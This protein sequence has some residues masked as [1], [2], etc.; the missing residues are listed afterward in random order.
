MF[1]FELQVDQ[2][3][4][5]AYIRAGF[6]VKGA[7][8]NASRLMLNDKVIAI[9]NR[10]KAERSKRLEIDAD[11]VLGNIDEIGKRCM[12]KTKVMI[13]DGK[14]TTQKMDITEEGEA[15]GVWEFK[16]HGAL[17]AQ[18]LLGKNLQMFTD[19]H[20]VV[21]EDKRKFT[22]AELLEEIRK[23]KLDQLI[24]KTK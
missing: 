4:T 10:L 1:C 9:T 23:R 16:E 15:V 13:R 6:A 20:V 14:K 3:Q 17:K 18:E 24:K 11:Y 8:Q 21:V 2:N 7:E 22:R 5:K 12:Q 19:K